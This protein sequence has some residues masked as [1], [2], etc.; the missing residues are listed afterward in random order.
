MQIYDTV[1][2]LHKSDL[3]SLIIIIIIISKSKIISK[4]CLWRQHNTEHNNILQELGR[5]IE[6]ATRDSRSTSSLD[7]G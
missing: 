1:R 5:R 4:Q 6:A 7:S 2:M 3:A